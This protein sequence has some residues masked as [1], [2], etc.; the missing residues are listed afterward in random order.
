MLFEASPSLF[1]KEDIEV[2][3]GAV[4]LSSGLNEKV[5]AYLSEVGFNM[6]PIR[7]AGSVG[8]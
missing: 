7:V 2:E 8:Y 5:S 6:I 3:T 4:F 1:S